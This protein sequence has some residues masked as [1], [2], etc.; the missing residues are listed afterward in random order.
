VTDL[1]GRH[2]ELVS[3]M[4]R[5]MGA[6]VGKR[7][8]WPGHQPVFSGEFDLIE[9]GDDVVFGSRSA[10][11]TAT[12][13]AYKK[14]TLSAGSNVSDNCIVLP[15]SILGKN[16]VLGSNSVCPE[17][18]YLPPD[19]IW[20]GSKN[21]EPVCL[22]RGSTPDALDA[23]DG[24]TLATEALRQQVPFEGD[25]TTLRPF[26]KAFYLGGAKY[27]VFPLPLIVFYSFVAKT[28]VVILHTL[29]LLGA[30]HM[31]G[32]TLYG[33]RMAGRDYRADFYDFSTVYWVWLFYYLWTNLARVAAWL[34]IELTAKWCFMGQR[35][36]GIYNYDTTSYAQR[37]ELYQIIG[38]V[39]KF[40]RMTFLE[41]FSGTPFL[42]Q[43]FRWNGARIGRDCCIYPAGADPFMPEPDLVTMGDRVVVDCAS[44]VCHLNTRGNFELAPIVLEDNCT[45]RARSRVQSGVR[46]ETGAQ[47]LEKSLAMTGE[48]MEAYSVW[49]GCPGSWWFQYKETSE[50]DDESS[51]SSGEKTSLLRSSGMHYV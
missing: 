10:I 19:S 16:A 31:T 17:G 20:L 26:G 44:I 37:W 7:V 24:A 43:Y 41:F 14:V 36:P 39:R 11:L 8:F 33:W 12:S 9:I 48:V 3:M 38:K 21:C 29:P 2:Y 23:L 45:L 34:V 4:Y 46:M 40:S 50:T 18:W 13:D 15:G 32:A 1:I 28:L 42:A 35:Q 51:N 5:A 30:M 49:Q 25:A 47:L 22:E 27:F 6:K